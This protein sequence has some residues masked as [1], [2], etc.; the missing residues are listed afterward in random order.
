MSISLKSAQFVN[1][2][3]A[4][5]IT[6]I[7]AHIIGGKRISSKAV[8]SAYFNSNK[9]GT[10][11]KGTHE[12]YK[13]VIWGKL[14]ETCC[15]VLSKGSE[16]SV[17][18]TP[19]SF[20]GRVFTP[21]GLQKLGADGQPVMTNKVSFTVTDIS[22][23]QES[24]MLIANEIATGRRPMNWDTD[25][26][27]D[28]ATWKAV[29]KQKHATP[30][31]FVSKTWFNARVSVPMGAQLDYERLNLSIKA[32]VQNASMPVQVANAVAGAVHQIYN[33]APVQQPV[34]NQAPVQ[35]PVYQNPAPQYQQMVNAQP[36][37]YG[38]PV[39]HVVPTPVPQQGFVKQAVPTQQVSF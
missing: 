37:F 15:K 19:N 36:Q 32:P 31:D 17:F 24:S 8:V 16:F 23:G 27:P 26:H 5:E 21:E 1:V 13:F 18:T 28:Q 11:G 34:Y 39:H 2:R 30:W 33:Q 35:Q 3:T 25:G 20:A 7:P 29:L 6:F 14:A 38:Q 10:D 22:F 12:S 9:G 4:G